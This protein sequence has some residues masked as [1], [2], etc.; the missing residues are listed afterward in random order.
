MTQPFKIHSA[1]TK[2]FKTHAITI[3]FSKSSGF[4]G[5]KLLGN[6][7]H[8]CQSSIERAFVALENL[9]IQRPTQKILINFS[10]QSAPNE[11][12]DGPHLDLPLVLGLH[13]LLRRKISVAEKAL[14]LGEINLNGEIKPIKNLLGYLLLA[15]RGEYLS[16]IIPA[17]NEAEAAQLKRFSYFKDLEIFSAA[18]VTEVLR[19]DFVEVAA[20]YVRNNFTAQPKSFLDMKL[21]HELKQAAEVIAVGGHSLL[22]IGAPGSGKTMFAERLSSI[23]PPIEDREYFDLV[24]NRYAASDTFS[25]A[26]IFQPWTFRSP[27]HQASSAAILGAKDHPGEIALAHGGILFLDEFPE[28]RRD[29][30]EGLREPLES[31]LIHVA[32]AK[33]RTSF[34]CRIVFVAAANP[35]PCGWYGS[36]IKL[37]HCASSKLIAYQAKISNPIKDRIDIH[38]K[39]QKDSS[40]SYFKID[41]QRINEAIIFARERNQ[42][43]NVQLNSLAQTS[44][45]D[46]WLRLTAQSIDLVEKL[47]KKFLTG[48]SRSRTL[49]LARTLADLDLSPEVEVEHVRQARQLNKPKMNTYVNQK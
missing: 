40:E 20:D 8:L 27:H 33:Y 9:G 38:L 17:G 48:R 19:E 47:E 49:K 24:S 13:G 31:G 37:C 2:N 39:M 16:V 6:V 3:D 44:N 28:F 23:L 11:K 30:I 14:V 34:H 4:T 42:E 41:E 25:S 22:M 35:C 32:R 18:H 21:S 45:I 36:D 12:I 26:E 43:F 46:K 7:S 29:V 10:C 15:A 5:P 1:F